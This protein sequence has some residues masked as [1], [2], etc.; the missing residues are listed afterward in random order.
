MTTR[1]RKDKQKER[2]QRKKKRGERTLVSRERGNVDVQ[3]GE[4][5]L[6]GKGFF[7]F[8][9]RGITKQSSKGATPLRDAG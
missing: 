3:K 2:P 1:K 9:W 5:F 8:A 7:N 6:T 4:H